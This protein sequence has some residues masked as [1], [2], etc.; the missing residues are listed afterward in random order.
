MLQL[1]PDTMLIR[2]WV[3]GRCNNTAAAYARDIAQML[4]AIGKPAAEIGLADLQAWADK[5]GALAPASRRRKLAAARS[6]LRYAHEVGAIPANP[7]QRLRLGPAA[8]ISPE[9]ILS[10]EVVHRLIGAE[11]D[12]RRRTLLR[13]LYVCALRESEAAELR[14][15]HLTA[16]KK[17]G[18]A[19]IHGKGGKVRPVAVPPTLWGELVALTLEPKPDSPVIPARSGGPINRAAVYRIVKR[20]AKRIGLPDISPHWLRHAHISHALDKGVGIHVAQKTAG[21]ADLRTTSKYAHVRHGESSS[22]Y[23]DG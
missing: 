3:H 11:P 23:L 15:R 12:M 21:H 4:A 13:L 10:E 17:G 22:T 9:R 6:L 20:A 5:L 16:R 2:A 1:G 14:W 8:S 18:E 19:L 7:A